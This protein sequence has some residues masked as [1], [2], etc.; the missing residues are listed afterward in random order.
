MRAANIRHF[1][2]LDVMR[3]IAAASITVWHFQ[4]FYAP[5]GTGLTA[6][7]DRTAQPFYAYLMPLY[8]FSPIAVQIFFC[9]SG[10]IFFWLY[11]DAIAARRIGGRAFFVLRLSRLY[12]LHLV[13]LLTVALIYAAARE[14]G[15][16]ISLFGDNTWENFG[17]Q[18]FLATHWAMPSAASFNGPIW[19]V[20][21]EVAAYFVFFLFAY[22]R[23]GRIWHIVAAAAL[24]LLVHEWNPWLG[25][26]LF[27]FFIG[28]AVHRVWRRL[29]ETQPRATL[30]TVWLPAFALV[31]F[32]SLFAAAHAEADTAKLLTWAVTVPAVVMLCALIQSVWPD[33]GCAT[34]GIGNFSYS[35]Y[36]VHFPV[37]LLII[38]VF[39]VMEW[40]LAV[41][42][43]LFL[44]Y[45]AICFWLSWL[46]YRWLEKPAQDVLRRQLL[47]KRIGV[48]APVLAFLSTHLARPLRLRERRNT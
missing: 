45:F 20:S 11:R 46:S 48:T 27:F 40:E 3:T 23:L 37:Q 34:D 32:G 19:T 5:D 47:G 17:L 14:A 41:T 39:T 4:L 10:F 25:H 16:D 28:G 9:M 1:Y 8:E 36:L 42:E 44:S 12:P 13:T 33:L 35:L 15:H 24:A 43:T 2:L 38:S 30:R 26:A 22:A 7:F 31:F 21:V 29:S 18:L 6:D